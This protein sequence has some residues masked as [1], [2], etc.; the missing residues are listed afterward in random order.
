M[1][2]YTSGV[3]RSN[4][5]NVKYVVTLALV[6]GAILVVGSLAR[7]RTRSSEQAPPSETDLALLARL[8]ERRALESAAGFLN[9]VAADVAPSLVWLETPGASGV[10]WAGNAIATARFDAAVERQ[11]VVTTST[12][13][14]AATRADWSPDLP[15]ARLEIAAP[16]GALP[17]LRSAPPTQSG[18]QLLA[19]WRT[20]QTHVFAPA[21]FI[22]STVAPCGG[23]RSRE[24]R[25]S[26]ALTP[27]MAGG[28]LFDMDGR[29][30]GVI[31]PCG[32]RY[33]AVA[34]D[35]V[36]GMLLAAESFGSRLLARYG[37]VVE[38]LTSEESA[39]FK[40]TAGVMIRELGIARPADRAGVRPGDIVVGLN[41][42]PVTRID[43]L[44]RLAAALP[45]PTVVLSIRRASASLEVD[46]V[47]GREAPEPVA[48]GAAGVVW[49]L[50]PRGFVIDAVQPGSRAATARLQP[51]DRVIRL[52]GNEPRTIDQ[53]R[54][55]FDA[56]T[57]T[58]VEFERDGRRRGALL[59]GEAR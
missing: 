5:P 14:V 11:L 6:A 23:H 15:L 58:F 51:G 27:A 32:E 18:A 40:T 26:L 37:L 53:L 10:L 34:S 52:D 47:H 55:G 56:R 25:T 41:G 43:D 33:A 2:V 20:A 44:G 30:L 59:P 17:P 45:M 49:E 31:L 57:G 24:V 39:F 54:R 19:V 28:G 13:D 12:G 29:L 8:T 36:D 16:P 35:V 22:E 50:P 1:A 4:A 38:P 9:Q 42:D 48:G 21:V 3:N 7:P 46:V